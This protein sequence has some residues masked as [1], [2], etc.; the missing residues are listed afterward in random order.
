MSL[1]P[2]VL[3]GSSGRNKF[4]IHL[5]PETFIEIL[6][7]FKVY[8]ALSLLNYLTLAIILTRNHTLQTR[9]SS[10][11][12]SLDICWIVIRVLCVHRMGAGGLETAYPA[13]I[14]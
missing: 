5:S 6:Y 3:V 10:I 8:S 11:N 9:R 1:A 7:F 2:M 14:R 12:A 13:V 4:C